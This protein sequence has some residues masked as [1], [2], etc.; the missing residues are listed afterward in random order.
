MKGSNAAPMKIHSTAR[1]LSA[2]KILSAARGPERSRQSGTFHL[3]SSTPVFNSVRG[4]R[5]ART[6]FVA[7]CT[8]LPLNNLICVI[9]EAST[10]NCLRHRNGAGGAR[11]C[12]HDINVL[13]SSA[14]CGSRP[15]P[16]L[17]TFRSRAPPR[18]P[19]PPRFRRP[20]W[21][22]DCNSNYLI[23]TIASL[24]FDSRHTD[25]VLMQAAGDRKAGGRRCGRDEKGGSRMEL[26][27]HGIA[28]QGPWR[29]LSRAVF[30]GTEWWLFQSPAL[31]AI[32]ITL[33][34]YCC[35]FRL[36]FFMR[37]ARAFNTRC[38]WKV[39]RHCGRRIA[40]FI[41]RLRGSCDG[42]KNIER[43]TNYVFLII[44]EFLL[45]YLI[46]YCDEK[47]L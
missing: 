34:W 23:S 15:S 14:L 10:T 45:Q 20:G 2:K 29:N 41:G 30:A 4:T 26:N 8:F 46:L 3:R 33:F 22:C 5:R 24:Y 37:T 39:G 43:E 38:I 27:V 44:C 25:L 18:V 32:V 31:R 40:I 7:E 36:Y 16:P 6:G 1:Q 35:A 42:R 21:N 9:P 12:E 47:I 19:L 17:P 11:G 28:R 13:C